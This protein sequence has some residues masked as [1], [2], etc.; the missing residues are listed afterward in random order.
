MEERLIGQVKWFDNTKNY[1][2]IIVKSEGENKDK[3][4][5]V[6]QLNIRA[7]GYRK[8]YKGEYVE[9]IY[10]END[11]ETTK[12]KHLFHAKDVSGI[13][14]GQLMC[15]FDRENVTDESQRYHKVN[16]NKKHNNKN[17]INHSTQKSKYG[18]GYNRNNN[19]RGNNNRGNNNRGAGA[20]V[21]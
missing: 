16:H 6:H 1:G 15:D 11:N 14:G 12:E 5:F 17:H 19:S 7:N 9:F 20:A 10:S 21:E 3:N 4:V 13:L 8:L 2:F 18:D